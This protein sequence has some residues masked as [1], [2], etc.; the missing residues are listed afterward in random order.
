MAGAT[1]AMSGLGRVQRREQMGVLVKQKLQQDEEG[2]WRIP[3]GD[4][5]IAIRDLTAHV[6]SVVDWGKEFVS[7]ALESSPYGSIAWAGVCLLLP[8]SMLP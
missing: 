1:V 2:K 7:A 5:R 8:V 6:V 3:L 4:D